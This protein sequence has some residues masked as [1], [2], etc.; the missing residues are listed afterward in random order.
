[1][2][3]PEQ[4]DFL[5]VQLEPIWADYEEYIIRE[6]TRLITTSLDNQMTGTAELLTASCVKN[7][8]SKTKLTAVLK[9]ALKRNDQ[10]V[11]NIL[12]ECGLLN[13]LQTNDSL[14]STGMNLIS[15]DEHP[16]LAQFVSDAITQ[17][18]GEMRN[19]TQT[20]GF[21][22]Q[23]PS[24]VKF[25]PVATFF[26]RQLDQA[27]FN[28]QA[29]AIS[30]IE[31]SRTVVQNMADSG[32]Q[33]V[34]YQSGWRNRS[35]VAV[36]RALVTGINQMT[37]QQNF[38][39]GRII[40]TDLVEVTAHQGARPSHKVWQGKIFSL[41]GDTP[42]YQTLEAGTGYGT[43][44]GLMGWNCRHN[45]NP[46]IEGTKRSWTDQELKN[47][48]PKDFSYNG[49]TYSFYQATQ[50]QR[51]LEN[52]MRICKRELI[53]FQESGDTEAF[54]K[55]STRLEKTKSEYKEFSKTAGLKQRDNRT[56]VLGFDH[57][58][59]MKSHW[60]NVNYLKELNK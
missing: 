20:Q 38:E 22:V 5:S 33:F 35:D 14:E 12:Q 34:D 52:R 32:L 51:Q 8:I 25:Q 17:T 7:G 60:A 56:Q 16:E 30:Y 24:G 1:M 10:A 18:K 47:I 49:K 39:M 48:D 31:A 40:G 13:I 53:G 9:K 28:V 41:H 59:S 43:G 4:T 54:D 46:Y 57:S 55:S 26:Q 15:I 50:R 2:I 3:T 27:V 42:G 44:A 11:Y 45:F 21:A 29:G 36:R 6:I 23:T 19:F 37:A 58:L